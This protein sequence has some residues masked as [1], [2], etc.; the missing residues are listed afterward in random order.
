VP[1]T[2]IMQINNTSTVTKEIVQ[3]ARECLVIGL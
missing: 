1:N 3:A 2:R